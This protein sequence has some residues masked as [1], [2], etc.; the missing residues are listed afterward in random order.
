M[1]MAIEMLPYLWAAWTVVTVVL[2]AMAI[3]DDRLYRAAEAGMAGYRRKMFVARVY[4]LEHVIVAVAIVWT[5]LFATC[6]FLWV[7][8]RFYR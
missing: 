8:T 4:E 6:I 3:R 7:W 1:K 5:A 2:T